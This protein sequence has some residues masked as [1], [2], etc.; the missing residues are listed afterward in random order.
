MTLV[1]AEFA[2]PV[3]AI[4]AIREILFG[5]TEKKEF[6]KALKFSF[7]ALAGLI[8]LLMLISG[9]FDMTSRFDDQLRSQGLDKIVDAIQKDRL[10]LF[11]SDAF[12]SLVFIALTATLIFFAWKKKI[13]F[14]TFIALASLL[15]LF[16]MWPFD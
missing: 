16:D 4:L 10:S 14:S 15:L 8:L 2:M 3:L 13:K 9:S 6:M 1:M 11:R 5:K 12:R 7:F